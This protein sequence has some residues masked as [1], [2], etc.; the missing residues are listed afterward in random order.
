MFWQINVCMVLEERGKTF[1][2]DYAL[3]KEKK[4]VFFSYKQIK[5]CI[6]N[7]KHDS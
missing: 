1:D 7:I 5:S 6:K 2:I 3:P 4:F